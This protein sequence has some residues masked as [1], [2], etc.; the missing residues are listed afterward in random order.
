MPIGVRKVILLVI[1][2]NKRVAFPFADEAN[3]KIV[4][5]C[6]NDSFEYINNWNIYL[7]MTFIF[8][9]QVCV[10][11]LIILFVNSTIFWGHIYTIRTYI[12]NQ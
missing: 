3:S 8:W 12:F 4:S 9:S 6:K 7:T 10:Y 11:Q 1:V 5:M 2:F